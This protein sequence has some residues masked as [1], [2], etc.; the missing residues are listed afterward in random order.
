[1][2][3]YKH[4]RLEEMIENWDDE[5]GLIELVNNSYKLGEGEWNLLAERVPQREGRYLVYMEGIGGSPGH[6][7]TMHWFAPAGDFLSR[8]VTHW[9]ELP[10]PPAGSP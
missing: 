5:S 9:R 1:M 6:M 4:P 7:E 8:T 2:S 10:L 3:K